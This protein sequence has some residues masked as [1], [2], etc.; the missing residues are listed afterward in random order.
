MADVITWRQMAGPNFSGTAAAMDAAGDRIKQG[1]DLFT[2]VAAD[3]SKVFQQQKAKV[4]ADNTARALTEIGALRDL[5]AL[6][7]ASPNLTFESLKGKFGDD[8]DAGAVAQ[9]AINQRGVIQ[10]NQLTDIQFN[11]AKLEA[12]EAPLV[13]EAKEAMAAAIASG[14]KAK[15]AEIEAFYTPKL[16]DASF[17][18]KA[19]QEFDEQQFN[20]NLQQSQE[21]RAVTAANQQTTLFDQEQQ[22]VK[23]EQTENESLAKQLEAN[24]TGEAK[25]FA[26]DFKNSNDPIKLGQ[27]VLYA[28]NVLISQMDLPPEVKSKLEQSSQFGKVL[29]DKV[30][31]YKNDRVEQE[32]KTKPTAH[33]AVTQYLNGLST[34]ERAA[35]ESVTTPDGVIVDYLNKIQVAPEGMGF[36]NLDDTWNEVGSDEVIE[37]IQYE[38]GNGE[39]NK[40]SNFKPAVV[41]AAMQGITPTADKKLTDQDIKVIARRIVEYNNKQ[42]EYEKNDENLTQLSKTLEDKKKDFSST[43]TNLENL[44]LRKARLTAEQNT[45]NLYRTLQ[46]KEELKK[47][48]TDVQNKLD[49]ALSDLGSLGNELGLPPTLVDSLKE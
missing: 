43:L 28:N 30:D 8:I 17:L 16:R 20:R 49:K 42:T 11:E 19:R 14:D 9:A 18:G 15:M 24:L 34:D 41:A 48:F 12:E 37:K 7:A 21:D 47:D 5:G 45:N 39:K 32:R 22:K 40:L 3:Q 25:G 23:R 13:G 27:K 29:L 38:L 33:S 10:K 36:L 4:K 2:Q 46:G 31:L 35:V 6:D 44:K 1:T 26:V